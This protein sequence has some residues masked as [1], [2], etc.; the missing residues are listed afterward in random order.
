VMLLAGVR[1]KRYRSSASRMAHGRACTPRR[2]QLNGG[3]ESS[4]GNRMT[5]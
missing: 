3:S 1:R 2:R 4:E 5:R